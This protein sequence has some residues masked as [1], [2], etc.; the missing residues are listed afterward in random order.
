MVPG[1]IGFA[2][3][4]QDGETG[5]SSDAD[6]SVVIRDTIMT[7]LGAVLSA[8]QIYRSPSKNTGAY[9]MARVF[10]ILGILLGATAVILYPSRIKRTARFVGFFFGRVFF[11]IASLAILVLDAPASI[12]PRVFFGGKHR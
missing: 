8:V 6:F 2:K 10:S 9:K 12:G 11:S 3:A 1:M 4:A 7:I 5:S